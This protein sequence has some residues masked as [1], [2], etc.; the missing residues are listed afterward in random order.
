MDKAWGAFCIAVG[1]ERAQRTPAWAVKLGILFLMRGARREGMLRLPP[2]NLLEH[3]EVARLD[4]AWERYREVS[5][6]TLLMVGGQERSRA[7][8][9]RDRATLG[10]A[11]GVGAAD[12]V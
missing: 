12:L 11:A 7:G 6:P 10:G 1:P 5:A 4:N 9:P 3:H 8:A 2:A